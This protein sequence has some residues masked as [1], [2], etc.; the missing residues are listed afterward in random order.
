MAWLKQRSCDRG[1][2][3]VFFVSLA[4]FG[5]PVFHMYELVKTGYKNYAH[6]HTQSNIILRQIYDRK[7]IDKHALI[8]Q[9]PSS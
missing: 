8:Q 5:I 7:N 9:K 1:G 2:A 6:T 3:R 4:T